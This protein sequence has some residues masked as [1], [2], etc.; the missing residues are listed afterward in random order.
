MQ[1]QPI[2]TTILMPPSLLKRLKLF[3]HDQR[4]P[5]SEIVAIAVRQVIETNDQSR[6]ERMYKGLF[7]LAG[8]G[9]KGVT[10][11]SSTIDET[12]YGADGAW[13]GVDG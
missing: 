6:L 11:A 10:D 13:K 2:R 8:A 7:A 9:T 5:V 3:A 4:R 1:V 12:L